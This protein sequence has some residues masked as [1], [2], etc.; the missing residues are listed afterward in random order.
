MY[1]V[2]DISSGYK[3]G[4]EIKNDNQITHESH[5]QYKEDYKMYKTFKSPKKAD[6]FVIMCGN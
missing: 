2:V 4:N 5:K 1:D 3:A 6:S